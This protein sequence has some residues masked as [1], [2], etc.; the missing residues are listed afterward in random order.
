M[1]NAR[2]L[3]KIIE[4]SF[5]FISLFPKSNVSIFFGGSRKFK[6]KQSL[7]YNFDRF[8][9]NRRSKCGTALVEISRALDFL[10]LKSTN[11]SFAHSFN[12]DKSLLIS[13]FITS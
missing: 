4:F 1:Y 7:F 6:K 8:P 13:D 9:L 12:F 3:L 5:I 2:S 11:H 10:G